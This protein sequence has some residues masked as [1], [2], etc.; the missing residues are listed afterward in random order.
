MRTPGYATDAHD[1]AAV[2]ALWDE[3]KWVHIKF[4]LG[5]LH[6]KAAEVIRVSC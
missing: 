5:G 1:D 2:E 6:I 4:D 3:S